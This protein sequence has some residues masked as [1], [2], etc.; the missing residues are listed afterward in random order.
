MKQ[1]TSESLRKD[2]WKRKKSAQKAMVEK[3]KFHR[4]FAIRLA[5]LMA[6]AGSIGL[7]KTQHKIHAAVQQVGWEI[8]ETVGS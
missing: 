4:A 7:Y 3:T 5:S 8:A 2:Y 6:E 1:P